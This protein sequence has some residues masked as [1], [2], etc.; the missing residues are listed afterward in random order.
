MSYQKNNPGVN[1]VPKPQQSFFQNNDVNKN[2][3]DEDTLSLDS[4]NSQ[5][6]QG[7]IN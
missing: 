3:D 6:S 7:F 2:D 5:R 1:K 4:H